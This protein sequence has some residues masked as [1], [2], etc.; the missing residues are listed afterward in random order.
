MVTPKQSELK[1]VSQPDFLKD[2]GAHLALDTIAAPCFNMALRST[3]SLFEDRLR[4]TPGNLCHQ[5]CLNVFRQLLV[6]TRSLV[7]PLSTKTI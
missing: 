2:G 1:V 6:K 5:G 7:I 3:S 4:N